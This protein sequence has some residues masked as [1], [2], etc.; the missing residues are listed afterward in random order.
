MMIKSNTSSLFIEKKRLNSEKTLL[1]LAQKKENFSFQN[2]DA[3]FTVKSFYRQTVGA[4]QKNTPLFPSTQIWKSRVRSRIAFFVWEAS[5]ENILI[6]DKLKTRGQIVVNGCFMC[7]R[8]EESCC[9][10]F[11]AR[12]FMSYGARFI[13][14]SVSI[15]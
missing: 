15:W 3:R 13:D 10:F 7:K 2:M 9:H 8:A 5:R 12:L 14:Y 11:T 1:F 4:G 6:L